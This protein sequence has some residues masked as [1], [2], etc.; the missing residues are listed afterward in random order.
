MLLTLPGDR[1][2]YLHH[3]AVHTVQVLPRTSPAAALDDGAVVPPNRAPG[4]G[5]RSATTPR[6][7]G[8]PPRRR[9]APAPCSASSGS[10][11]RGWCWRGPRPR[12]TRRPRTLIVAGYDGATGDLLATTT[13]PA[14]ALTHTGTAF[15]N[16]AAGVT[17]AGPVCSPPRPP[18]RRR[19]SWC[20]GSP[21]P[22]SPTG[23]T[24]LSPAKPAVVDPDGT[25]TVLP[26][27]TLTPIGSGGTFLPVLS[28]GRLYALLPAGPP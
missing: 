3:G 4:P 9:P 7:P 14:A 11:P 15:G 5:G 10:P 17:A 26:D 28:Q 24:A 21:P 16:D 23:C 12:P 18:G 27:G 19:S 22:R 25:P 1:V 6:P 2:G 8:T 20:P 13:A